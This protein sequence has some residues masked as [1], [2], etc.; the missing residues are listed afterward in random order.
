M[1][2]TMKKMFAIVLALTLLMT[3][4][5][6]AYAMPIDGSVDTEAEVLNAIEPRVPEVC[7]GLP[8]HKLISSGWG[9]VYLSSGSL[10]IDGGCAWQCANCGLVMVTQGDIIY[11]QMQPIGKWAI[12]YSYDPISGN[13]C[14]IRGPISTGQTSSNSLNG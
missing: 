14:V 13:G 12:S 6:S 3:L 2:R 1:K 10:Y 11:G 5:V 7:G 8:Y 4:G 9:R